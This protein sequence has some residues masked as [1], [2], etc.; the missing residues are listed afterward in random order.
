MKNT[1]LK[2]LAVFALFTIFGTTDIQA[3]TPT[4]TSDS[5][6]YYKV[7]T[8]AG[9]A[10]GR[11]IRE[12][13]TEIEVLKKDG[14]IIIIPKNNIISKTIIPN[15]K[16]LGPII[17]PT[18]YLYAPSAIPL[19][20]GEGY[21]NL[22][23]GLVVQAQYGI[24]D[25]VSI[26][27]TTTPVFMPTFVNAK[28][29]T[30]IN[31]KMYVSAGGQ[32]GKLWYGDEESL[33]L[34]FANFTYGTREANITFNAGYGFYT[35]SKN[36]LPILEVSG[37]YQSSPK[38]SLVGELWILMHHDRPATIIGGPA[39]RINAFKNGF[40]DIGVLSAGFSEKTYD[41]YYNNQTGQYVSQDG[42]K[43][44]SYWPIPFLSLGFTF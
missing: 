27:M 31:E 24:T 33:G 16:K 20:K 44:N 4:P 5:V 37:L 2:A 30:K 1:L 15:P 22:I 29:A 40:I 14:T 38:V 3:Q 13:E 32:L 8:A 36:Q 28:A 6:V 10:E 35:Q 25:Y 26:G 19:K 9:Y 42:Y 12:T 18:R 7:Q 21:L 17:H 11:I 39:L 41:G 43:R 34:L 23:Y